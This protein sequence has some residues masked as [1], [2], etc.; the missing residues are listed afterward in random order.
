[1]K[2]SLNHLKELVKTDIDVKELSRLFNLHSAEVEEY[3]NLV[4]ATNLVVGHV[5][6]KEQHPDAD[7]LSVCQ[8]DIGD[9]VEQIVCG[10]PNVEAGQNVIVS[11]VGAELAGG[12]KIKASTIRGVSSNGMICSLAELGIDK[13]YCDA[14]GIEVIK[15]PSQPGEN[16]LKVLHLDD[17][18]MS[19]DLTPN[20]ADLLSVMGVAY[21]TAA[22]LDTELTLRN[23]TLHETNVENTVKIALETDNCPS[24]YARIIDDIEIKPSPRWMQ[25][26]LIAMGMRPI[27]NVV[28]ITNYVM[29]ETGQPLH[30]FDYETIP[31]DTILV[32]MAKE[33]EELITLDEQKRILTTEDIVITDGEKAIALGG[34]MGGFDTEIT[35]KTTKI[36]LESATFNPIHIRKTSRRLDLRSE[37]STRF[38]RRV[39]PARTTLALD[40]T[41][42]LLEKYAS[43][44]VR[45]GRQFVDNVDYTE[46]VVHTST[47]QINDNLG[48]SLTSHELKEVL[49]RL[50]FAFEQKEND[51]IVTIPSRRQDMTGYQDLVEEI[52]RIV[53]YDSLPLTLPQTVTK[54]ALKPQ[55]L[56]RREL[57]KKLTA[58]GLN[59]VITYS[60]ISPDRCND[61][62][63]EHTDSIALD[64]PMSQD[65]SVLT[66]SPLMG[67]IDVIKYNQARKNNDIFIFEVGKRYHQEEALV[68]SGALTGEIANTNWQG[69]KEVVDFYSV[70]GMIDSLLDSLHLSHLEYEATNLYKNLHPGQA[71]IIKDRNG[72]LGFIGKLH[73]EYAKQHDLKNVYVFELEVAK[74]FAS[75]RPLK[76]V[77]EINKFP[78]VSRDIAIVLDDTVQASHILEAINKAGKRMLVSSNIFDL[79]RGKPLEDHQKSL[80]INL[81]FSDQKRTLETKEVDQRVNEILGVLKARFNAE[82]RE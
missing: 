15:E 34:V 20:R 31:T 69:K 63:K 17:Q 25:S 49:R 64:L 41:C 7:K 23:I 28:D 32:R 2:V 48:S 26:R 52:G 35:D 77:K 76:K 57:K 9:K 82:L 33:K 59:E 11:K 5:I 74:L 44:K 80:A 56:F 30:A 51:F 39:D 54:G 70:K 16:P 36:L 62:T 47:K 37:A 72:E 75:Q 22:I 21:D 55:Q 50:R 71:A 46:T 10:A 1:M 68:V 13:K 12:F 8:V 4:D 40:L 58:L 60:L 66:T 29:L 42:E 78:I 61:F 67:M 81:L 79:Y 27:N 14:S 43:G 53:G 45:K 38:E 3:K 6:Q 24:Y 18:V 19:L 73:P 65:K